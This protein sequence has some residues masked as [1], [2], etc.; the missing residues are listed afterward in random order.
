M[1]F[2]S[3]EKQQIDED[4]LQMMTAIG[5]QIGQ[6]IKRKQ[7]EAALAESEE[8]YRDLFEGA[9]DLIQSVDAD[10]NFIYVNRAWR[11]TL[12]YSGYYSSRF[13]DPFSRDFS[14]SN[15]WKKHESS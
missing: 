13:C 1:I 2:Y 11:E 5:S 8:R 6:F 14:K 15:V 7:A 4:L 10:G 9:S 12:G 3:C